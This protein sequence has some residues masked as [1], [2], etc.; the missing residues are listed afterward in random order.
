VGGARGSGGG[1]TPVENRRPPAANTRARTPL[2]MATAVWPPVAISLSTRLS[3]R[4]DG[5]PV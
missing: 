1:R 5:G 2:S 3:A 4:V